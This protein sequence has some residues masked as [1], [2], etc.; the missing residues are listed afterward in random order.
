MRSNG[1]EDLNRCEY[2]R[3]ASDRGYADHVRDVDADTPARFNADP[4]SLFEA[5]GSAGKVMLFAVRLDTFEMEDQTA[6]FYIGSNDT[7]ELEL[8][9]RHML[10]N[11][12][13]LPI[14]GVARRPCVLRCNEVSRQ[15]V[16]L[17]Q[18][19]PF[20]VRI[21]RVRYCSH[22]Y[23]V[24]ALRQYMARPAKPIRL[25][26][27]QGSGDDNGTS[28][29]AIPV[30]AKNPEEFQQFFLAVAGSKPGVPSPTPIEVFQET[31]SAAKTFLTTRDPPPVSY[32]T[33]TYFGVNSFKFVNEKGAVT[34][35]RYQLRPDAGRHFLSK[36]ESAKAATNYLE[37][38]IRQRV[39]REAV[40]F[41][42][43]LQLAAPGDKIDDPSVAWAA[44]NKITALGTLTV[45]SVVPDSEATER[46][47]M[48][49]PALLPA[50]IE[51]ADPIIQFRNKTY[52][53]SYERRHQ[54]QPVGATAMVE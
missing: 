1:Y 11:F 4:R 50:G 54:S 19:R 48:F 5:S 27:R 31:H 52:P 35:G 24:A 42:V 8:I 25:T 46:A 18:K 38:E 29:A 13:S 6:V 40:L 30:M 45:A 39:A 47:L 36:D 32:A 17:G 26:T 7:S 51:P 15:T 43:V 28:S 22:R 10:A 33:T 3:V 9:R 20:R 23:R 53:V 34:I 44:T 14:S 49:L 2:P 12:E 37:E 41:K 16:E 21:R